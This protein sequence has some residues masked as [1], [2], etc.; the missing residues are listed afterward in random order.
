MIGVGAHENTQDPN[1]LPNKTMHL[2][3]LS[4]KVRGSMRVTG[5]QDGLQEETFPL[6]YSLGG[7]VSTSVQESLSALITVS[8]PKNKMHQN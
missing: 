6:E 2:W 8:A 5:Y 7:T 1:W 3:T 4:F